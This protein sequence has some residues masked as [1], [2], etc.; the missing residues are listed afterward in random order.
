MLQGRM[1][2]DVNEKYSTKICSCCDRRTC[3]KGR[4]DLGIREW[5]CLECGT[6]HHRDINAA[7]N[8]L[9]ARR[10]RLAEGIPALSAPGAAAED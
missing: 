5:A 4:E 9:A 10:R 6:Y 3:Q 2:R 7:V 8:I 1:V